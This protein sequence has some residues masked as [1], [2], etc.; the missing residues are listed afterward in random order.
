MRLLLAGICIGFGI[1]CVSRD[2]GIIKTQVVTYPDG[3]LVE[4]NGRPVGR[5]PAAVVLPQ[6]SNGRL[7][8][9]VV[10]RAV[11]NTAQKTLFAQSRVLDPQHREAPVPHQIMIDMTLRDTNSPLP[12]LTNQTTHVET[13]TRTNTVRRSRP[14]ESGKPTRPVGI[15][16]WS[17]G[18]Y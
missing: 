7:T 18:I 9:R 5:A 1:A 8:E 2:P 17:P 15:D 12:L 13:A 10:V 4:F 3:A 6:D 16:R 14:A 11:P